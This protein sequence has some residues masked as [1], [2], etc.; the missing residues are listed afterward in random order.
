MHVAL[1]KLATPAGLEPATIRLEGECSI[2]LSYGANAASIAA[3]HDDGSPRD[4]GGQWAG[5][6]TGITRCSANTMLAVVPSPTRLSSRNSAPLAAASAR[7]KGR[8]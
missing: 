4:E 3:N 1:E 7:T 2:Q 6:Q 8:P 5:D